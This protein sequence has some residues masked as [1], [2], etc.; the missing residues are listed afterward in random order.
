[1]NSNKIIMSSLLF[2]LCSTLSFAQYS[3]TYNVDGGTT[4]NPSSYEQTDITTTV[5]IGVY[6]LTDGTYLDQNKDL[7]YYTGITCQTW[8]RSTLNG[9]DNYNAATD[10]SYDVATS[11]ITWTEFG[12][13]Q[14]QTN[15]EATCLAGTEGA[16]K[17]V[18]DTEYLIQD[19]G[20]SLGIEPFYLRIKSVEYATITLTDAIKDGYTFE[21]WFTDAAFTNAI[22]EI[23]DGTTEN[24]ELFAKYTEMTTGIFSEN[25]NLFSFYPNPSTNFIH[26]EIE[27][28]S[29]VVKNLQ[30]AVVSEFNSN[31]SNYD[32]SDLEHGI[33]TIKATDTQGVL[34]TSK[35]IKE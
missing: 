17:T 19:Q 34:Y 32:I 7:I 13:E 11:A 33:Y 9:T 30:G 26:T 16:T 5:T 22:T 24:I 29:L 1:M 27:L 18:N 4:S 2:L 12:P 21:G 25:T 31:D 6:K 28:S 35:L 10:V 14:N 23:A 15:I 3:I 8:S 20:S